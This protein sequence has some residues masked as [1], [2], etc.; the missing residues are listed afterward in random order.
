MKTPTEKV[1]KQ[2]KPKETQSQCLPCKPITS[3]N[4]ILDKTFQIFLN[5]K[6][7]KK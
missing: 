3:G 1:K 5:K 6:I 4:P 7:I 2:V